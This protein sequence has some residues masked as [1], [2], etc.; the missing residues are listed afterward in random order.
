MNVPLSF[1]SEVVAY[2]HCMEDYGPPVRRTG[3][4]VDG[5]H[6]HPFY[7]MDLFPEGAVTVFL[8][9]VQVK[10]SPQTCLLIPPMTPHG[11]AS[12]RSVMVNTFKFYLHPQYWL[13]FQRAGT[14]VSFPVWFNTLNRDLGD[15]P[16]PDFFLREQGIVAAISICL[17]YWLKQQSFVRQEN[18]VRDVWGRRIQRI[19]EEIAAEPCRLW[20]VSELARRCHVSADYFCKQFT[21]IV[22]RSPQ[23]FLLELRMRTAAAKLLSEDL[24]IKEAAELAGYSSVHSFTRAFSSLFD[25]SPARYIKTVPQRS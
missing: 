11:Y 5:V 14:P 9:G 20:K 3:L 17:V 19:L 2:H 12:E 7:Q 21:E 18:G 25:T 24:P 1:V 22:G 15:F 16:E 23:R 4:P 10:S 13:R 6:I 8:D